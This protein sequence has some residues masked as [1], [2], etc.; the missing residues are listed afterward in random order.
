[1]HLTGFWDAEVLTPKHRAI[2]PQHPLS[3]EDS[4]LE[5]SNLL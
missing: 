3:P 2:L 4:D 5:A 1:M